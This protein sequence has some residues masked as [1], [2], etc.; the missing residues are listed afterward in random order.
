MGQGVEGGRG[1][2]SRVQGP[3]PLELELPQAWM[4]QGKATPIYVGPPAT[5]QV[6]LQAPHSTC[7]QRTVVRDLPAPGRHLDV[8]ALSHQILFFPKGVRAIIIH[9]C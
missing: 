4:M 9:R 3:Q 5:L 2:G 6:L 1:R 8:D 7:R